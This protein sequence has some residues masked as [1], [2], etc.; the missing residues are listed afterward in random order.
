[1]MTSYTLVNFSIVGLSGG[2]GLPAGG[3][4]VDDGTMEQPGIVSA[5]GRQAAPEQPAG[6]GHPEHL[7]QHH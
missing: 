7:P 4:G 6:P 1:M 5:A 3:R 2:A